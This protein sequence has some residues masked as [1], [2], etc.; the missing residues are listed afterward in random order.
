MAVIGTLRGRAL[1]RKL[2][3]YYAAGQALQYLQRVGWNEGDY[4]AQDIAEG[5]FPANL[6]N[7]QVIVR[8]H[9]VSFVNDTTLMH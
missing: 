6:E 7:L 5:R 4:T 9:Y 3:S 8:R 2:P 1:I